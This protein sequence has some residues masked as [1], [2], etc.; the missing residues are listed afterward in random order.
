MKY[1]NIVIDTPRGTRCLWP[2]RKNDSASGSADS[3]ATADLNGD[4]LPDLIITQAP[5]NRVVVLL[6]T[7][8]PGATTLSFAAPQTFA[9][10]SRPI[11]VQTADVN[12]DGLPDLIVFNLYSATLG[13]LL[14]TTAPGASVLTFD[15]Y[16]QVATDIAHVSSLAVADVNGDGQPD[17]IFTD[18]ASSTVSVLLDTTA[19]GATTASFA[20]PQTFATGSDPTSVAVS[21]LNGDGRPDLIV[22]NR[23]SNTVS[24]LLN[25]TA[26]GATTPSFAAQQSFATGISPNMV[27]AADVNGDGR[28]DILVANGYSS[29]LGVLLNT[30]APGATTLSFAAQQTFATGGTPQSVTVADLNGDGRPDVLLASYASNTVSVMLNTPAVLGSNPATGTI[31][32][33]PV[34]SSIDLADPSPSSAATVHFTITFSEAVTGVTAANFVLTGTGTSG[35]VIGTPTT[36]NGGI[37]WT[38]TVTTGGPGTLGLTLNSRTGIT[39]SFGNILYATTSDNGSSFTPIAGPLYTIESAT[40]TSVGSSLNAST[41][42]QSVTFTA[43]V[44]SSGTP[45]GTVTFYAGAVNPANQIG[46]GMLERGRRPGRGHVQHFNTD[47]EW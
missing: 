14:N 26:P 16:Q 25:T 13:V 35:A 46:T 8:D 6:N 34:V 23:G 7:T 5:F 9:T 3:V 17:L 33:A 28:P 45:T 22:A 32:S 18:P 15:P 30:T 20:A 4:G 38:V 31:D 37:T 1:P 11:L 36:S 19:P 10:D 42:G 12:G 39:D 40:T 27:T 43:T 24:V 21:D 44:T 47:S 29:N 41:Y 2:P